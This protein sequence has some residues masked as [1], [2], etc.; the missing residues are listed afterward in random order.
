MI[1]LQPKNI[2]KVRALLYNIFKY[3]FKQYFRFGSVS[4]F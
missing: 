2:N 4:P 1:Q 3:S